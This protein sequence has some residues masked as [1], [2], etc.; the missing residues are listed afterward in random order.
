VLTELSDGKIR[1][2]TYDLWTDDI[3]TTWLQREDH[4]A[5][6]PEG[7]KAFACVDFMEIGR[8][9]NPFGAGDP[10]WSNGYLS[11][12]TYDS[13]QEMEEVLARWRNESR[14]AQER[15]GEGL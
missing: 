15:K 11:I 9:D 4:F 13:A 8:G 7:K 6:M 3:L 14:N 12:Y 5:G 1:M 10:A 2:Y